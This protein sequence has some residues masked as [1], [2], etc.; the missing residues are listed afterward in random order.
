[1]SMKP[2]AT[3]KAAVP[4]IRSAPSSAHGS[5][6][7]MRVLPAWIVSAVVHIVIILLFMLVTLT[8]GNAGATVEVAPSEAAQIEDG[9]QDLDLTVNEVGNDPEVPTTNYNVDR[10]ADVSVPG[11]ALPSEPIGIP[12]APEGPAQ[13][14]PPPPGIGR[15]TGAGVAGDF[16]GKALTTDGLAGGFGG[17][18]NPGGFGGRSAATREKMVEEGGGSKLSEATV[19][20]GLLWL[21]LH[22]GS[23][24]R[25]SLDRFHQSARD[26]PGLG[27]KTFTCNCTG[28]G[29]NNDIAGTAF[30]L[31]PFLAA[32]ITPTNNSKMAVDYTKTVDAAIKFLVSRQNKD[33]DFGGGMYAHG[34]ATIAV[35]E[36]YGLTSDPKLRTP[37]QRA[38][39]FIVGAQDA[40]VGGWRYTPRSGGDT[41]VVGWQVMALKSGQMAGLQVPTP[42]LKGADKWLDSC[43]TPDGGGYGYTGPGETPTMSAVGLLCRQYLGWSP[44]NPGLLAGVKR[45]RGTPPGALN[46]VYYNYYATQVMHHMGGDSWEFWNA[47][48]RDLLIAAADKGGDGRRAHHKGSWSAAGDAHGAQGGRVMQTSL[49]LLTLEVYYRHLPLYRRDL[50]TG[51]EMKQ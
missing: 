30:G 25:F 38:I 26:K 3:G 8:P 40:A 19:G 45:L 46:S 31:L 36:A 51:K 13:T 44:R 12:G 9:R 16:S 14:V 21:A 48:M 50:A 4:V 22:Q 1:M 5:G 29:M 32:G 37:A 41:S 17:A 15:G 34:I 28:Q 42:A 23:D 49:S 6:S 18:F 33:G 20:S 10:L 47:K 24:G 11:M 35:C 2:Q 7:L 27:G 39:N 43:Q